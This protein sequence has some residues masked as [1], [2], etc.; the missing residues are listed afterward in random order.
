MDPGFICRLLVCHNVV[1]QLFR[2]KVNS[3]IKK[4]SGLIRSGRY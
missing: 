3:W 4:K 2:Q 1:F